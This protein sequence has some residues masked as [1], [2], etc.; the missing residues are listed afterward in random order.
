MFNIKKRLYVRRRPPISS[1][2]YRF[3]YE[4][5][6]RNH[7]IILSEKVL[8]HPLELDMDTDKSVIKS[9]DLL[10]ELY[11]HYPAEKVNRLQGL[12]LEGMFKVRSA[13]KMQGYL[14]RKLALQKGKI[15]NFAN[16]QIEDVKDKLKLGDKDKK[17]EKDAKKTEEENKEKEEVK[18]EALTNLYEVSCMVKSYDRIIDNYDKINKR[19]SIDKL[20]LEGVR[21]EH[22]AERNAITVSKLVNTYNMSTI[23][24]FKV[25]LENYIFVLN[26]HG[27]KHD[28][29]AIIEAVK[30]Y[31]ETQTDDLDQFR[32]NLPI[33]LKS[34]TKYNPF[35]MSDV[36]KITIGKTVTVIEG[37]EIDREDVDAESLATT[38][39]KNIEERDEK[40]CL[41]NLIQLMSMG[42]ERYVIPKIDTFVL[43]DIS[44]EGDTI[45]VPTLEKSIGGYTSYSYSADIEM[46]IG[47]VKKSL[48]KFDSG[49]KQMMDDFVDTLYLAIPDEEPLYFDDTDDFDGLDI[50]SERIDSLY[51]SVNSIISKPVNRIVRNIKNL[52]TDILESVV[53]AAACHPAI[54]EKDVVLEQ[55]LE[56]KAKFRKIYNKTMD[57]YLRADLVNTSISLL[58]KTNGVNYGNDLSRNIQAAKDLKEYTSALVEFYEGTYFNEMDIGNVISVAVDKFKSTLKGAANEITIQSR[59]FDAGVEDFKNVVNN[60]VHSDDAKAE[61]R[62]AVISGTVVPKASRLVKLAL[63]SGIGLLINPAIA[64]IVVLGYLGST[65]EERSKER[66]IVL[67]EI[68]VELE[69]TNRYLKK[70]EDDNQ[71]EK[72]RELLKI[73]K[74]LES[75]KARLTYNMLFKHGEHVPGK[76][77]ED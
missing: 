16:K 18:Q 29:V 66:K 34:M 28:P 36:G 1:D 53:Y 23:D 72:Q 46:L 49:D 10:M 42:V 68:E 52:P 3:I 69:M 40:A 15:T 77:E 24:K 38:I 12:V 2:K 8:S 35:N 32:H 67:D 61:D 6:M 19:F 14:S 71:L 63:A 47:A 51:E 13:V 11:N 54:F 55:L 41:T 64:I 48:A 25:A 75:Q 56:E 22:D 65:M 62:E 44:G 9:I 7:D 30:S 60:L 57:Q 74:K 50:L 26:K 33:L 21:N 27:K 37:V 17:K 20:V 31:F 59:Q 39:R 45:F 5:A 4:S 73:K 76:K 43:A 58:E 70:A